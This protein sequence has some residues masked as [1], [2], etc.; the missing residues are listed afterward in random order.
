MSRQFQMNNFQ[1]KSK[2]RNFINNDNSDSSLDLTELQAQNSQ[3]QYE[4]TNKTEILSQISK[5]NN[6]IKKKYEDLLR[7]FSNQ[8]SNSTNTYSSPNPTTN[9]VNST[10][11]F[12][13][14]TQSFLPDEKAEREIQLWTEMWTH[15]VSMIS[16]VIPISTIEPHSGNE[17]RAILVDLIS[18]LCQ[19]AKDPSNDQYS[20]LLKKYTKI[21]EK[22]KYSQQQQSKMTD[23]INKYKQ[24]L[25]QKNN[26]ETINDETVLSQKIKTLEGLLHKLIEKQRRLQLISINS[27]L[28]PSIENGSLFTSK[29]EQNQSLRQQVEQQNQI[30]H[31]VIQFDED[32]DESSSTDENEMNENNANSKT[33]NYNYQNSLATNNY[34]KSKLNNHITNQSLTKT[35]L[36]S[37][38]I[39]QTNKELNNNNS[40]KKN[41]NKKKEVKQ[42]ISKRLGIDEIS[43]ISSAVE[44]KEIHSRKN[45]KKKSVNLNDNE[46]VD[47]MYSN[48]SS[49]NQDDNFSHLNENYRHQLSSAEAEADEILA[50]ALKKRKRQKNLEE[51][52]YNYEYI[53]KTKRRNRSNSSK[54]TKKNRIKNDDGKEIQKSYGN[55]INQLVS[56]A[57]HFADD[58]YKLGKFFGN[59]NDGSEYSISHLSKLHDSLLSVEKQ[60]DE[61]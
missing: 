22:L 31:R 42:S 19:L 45:R 5:E 23:E 1:K 6:E 49:D 15:I 41:L 58:Y 13:N 48:E 54:S 34:T 60:L 29:Q 33:N 36:S 12:E 21:K 30:Q 32:S 50:K 28:K 18:R 11:F 7:A 55:H 43:G 8:K 51:N 4:N 40:Y 14:M 9:T 59:E 38:Q 25:D 39:S 10:H 53:Q 61:V 26:A 56:L 44:N 47:F 2:S 16:N 20:N 17:R 46:E 27:E 24:L 52:N 3:F 57:N 35:K 37:S